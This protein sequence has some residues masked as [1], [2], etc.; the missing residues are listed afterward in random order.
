M[1]DF[2]NDLRDTSFSLPYLLNTSSIELFIKE[3]LTH[4]FGG[5]IITDAGQTF[6]AALTAPTP[7]D[8]QMC[9]KA[10]LT[11]SGCLEIR[12]SGDKRPITFSF[13]Y[14]IEGVFVFRSNASSSGHAQTWNWHPRFVGK[15][16]FKII[17]KYSSQPDQIDFIYRYDFLDG[18]YVAC[19]PAPID[20][21]QKGRNMP[22]SLFIPS[23][24]YLLPHSVE[25]DGLYPRDE[26]A[27]ALFSV[28]PAGV[29]TV[30]NT[31]KK[32]IQQII[33]DAFS[34]LTSEKLATV[35]EQDLQWQRLYTYSAYLTATITSALCNVLDQYLR[36]VKKQK[37]E[38]NSTD[39]WDLLLQLPRDIVPISNLI[40]KGQLHL[41]DPLNGIEALSKLSSFQRYPYS[42]AILD[43]LPPIFR[44]NHPS[45]QGVI[46]PV[47]SPE[48]LK[49]GIAL[50]LA[51][52]TQTD[53]IGHIRKADKTEIDEDL[54]RAA[55][56]VPFYQHNDGVRAMM[57]AKNLKQAAP[58]RARAKP[59]VTTG[60]ETAL[61]ETAQ[62]LAKAG[63]SE[64]N[65]AVDVGADLLVAYM[66]WYGWN[67]D[68]AIV[69]NERLVSDGSLDWVVENDY[70]EYLLPGFSLCA[71]V[72]ENTFEEAFKWLS[73]GKSGL[74]KLGPIRPEDPI[75]FFRNANGENRMPV[76]CRAEERGELVGLSYSPPPFDQCGGSLSWK[77][78]HHYPFRV[79]D[80]IMGRHGNKG[81]VAKILPPDE[82]PRLPD[83]GRLP[84]KLRGKPV[85]LILNPHGVISRMN[86]GQLLETSVG[87]LMQFKD[88]G[89]QFPQNVGQAF[90]KLDI[91]ALQ[92]YFVKINGNHHPPLFDPYGR[93]HMVMPSGP[94]TNAPVT[95][96]VQHILRLK[97][98]AERKAQVRAGAS[99]NNN[100][101]GYNLVSGQPVGGRR[102]KGGQRLGE[103]EMW[104]LAAHGAAKSIES[105]LTIK[106]DPAAMGEKLPFGQTFQAIKDHL[107]AM[108]IVCD[109]TAS[110]GLQLRWADEADIQNVC[111][112]VTSPGTWN[113]GV[114]GHFIC[115]ANRCSYQ[116]PFPSIATGSAQR[117]KQIRLTMND[118]L[119]AKGLRLPEDEAAQIPP[120]SGR[121]KEGD[122]QF[123]FL[124]ADG[125]RKK[126]KCTFHYKRGKRSVSLDFTI[127]RDLF[128]AYKQNDS[129][130]QAISLQQLGLFWLTCPFHKSKKLVEKRQ[131]IIPV[132]EDGG[133]CDQSIFGGTDLSIWTPDAFGAIRLDEAILYPGLRPGDKAKLKLKSG[134]F[135]LDEK[136]PPPDL[137]IFPVLPM[138]YRYR[139]P[140]HLGAGNL[141]Q[142]DLLT[143]RYSKLA[144]LVDQKADGQQIRD[145]ILG[146]IGIIHNRLFGK[147]GLLRRAGLGRRVDMSARLVIVPDP[148]LGWDTCAVPIEI[149]M[150]LLG[151]EISKHPEL[152]SEFAQVDGV[153][154]LIKAIFGIDLAEPQVPQAVEQMVLNQ[155]FWSNP[156]WPNKALAKDHLSLAGRV[157]ERYIELHPQTTVLLNRQ[158][159]LHR[160]SIMGFK[161]KVLPPDDG[162]VLKINPLVCNGFGADFD[163]DE[164]ALHMPITN[165][166]ML[167]AETMLPTAVANLFSNANG[168]PMAH[169][170]QDFVAG[171]FYLSLSGEGRH[172]LA[173]LF[174][175]LNCPD[176]DAILT[177][178]AP[179][180]KKHGQKMIDHLCHHHP[181]HAPSI[182]QEW[183]NLAYQFVTEQGMSFGFLELWHLRQQVT[184]QTRKFLADAEKITDPK[185]L[186][187]STGTFGNRLLEALEIDLPHSVQSP[188][189]GLAA[190]ALS[191]ARGTKQVRQLIGARGWLDPG[192]VG[193][194][195]Q[196]E[197]FFCKKS[198]V[199]GVNQD[200]SYFATMN[201]RSSM[202]DKKLGTGQAGYLTRRLVLAAWPW[203]VKTG[204]CGADRSSAAG[205][206]D[207]KWQEHCT[208]CSACYGQ[209]P[210][211]LPVP[212][213]YP[214]G[215]IAAQSFG[216]RGT[217]LSMQS[218]HTAERQLSIHEVV[219]LLGGRDP[220]PGFSNKNTQDADCKVKTYN[221]FVDKAD[222]PKYLERIR[223]ENGY[224]QIDER[225]LLLIW[226]VIH[227]SPEK[228]ISNAWRYSHS[229]LAGLIG[230]R[231]WQGLLQAICTGAYDDL[232]SP[233]TRILTSQ[234][235]V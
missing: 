1:P 92:E 203:R 234:S 233:L 49:V 132:H 226:L 77:I 106:S 91:D 60:H 219:A 138:K 11:L 68:D 88:K 97:H 192:A 199:E 116:L 19:P 100:R 26:V 15:P 74:R 72:F 40:T 65:L 34:T 195:P 86:L 168:Q 224:K 54:G 155:A 123:Q 147:M 25:D 13:P 124:A 63:I 171:H 202:L 231:Q 30:N 160:F 39:L 163:G 164:M 5:H 134:S 80:K 133:L 166:E 209:L 111:K 62:R 50:H 131:R 76:S 32:R 105:A 58:V 84:E 145:E 170:D 78:R 183:M 117:D 109:E 223:R 12:W 81:I 8:V 79:G 35:D 146:I 218:F 98:V 194:Q 89:F 220:E 16:G 83:D 154:D 129:P 43:R 198:L 33:S 210:P 137:T 216:E 3:R 46:C 143:S 47:E 69:A 29:V 227:R 37:T 14:P 125:K 59:V 215:L 156:I 169:F 141:P 139:A 230:P 52:N 142:N 149:L 6:S 177:E 66:P 207:C 232:N 4:L 118:L 174:G 151:P 107:F 113:V 184:E 119:A 188:G 196:S 103:M 189:F 186:S 172:K 217:Q 222:V 55:S 187:A 221:W 179:W 23:G 152:L 96:G 190:M 67:V 128:A 20:C 115:E 176:C 41:F 36:R 10:N 94:K 130:R 18:R 9:Q 24:T 7:D 87:M 61:D 161:I 85:D 22:F 27:D 140:K 101:Y 75:A 201:G 165:E 225:H 173:S 214:A 205:L 180:K 51:R 213:G 159:S 2:K 181:T 182:I 121:S 200:E 136:C 82:L 178:P 208:I 71:P 93:I 229:P 228:T 212:D 185:I 127:G 235:P 70:F 148:D 45:Y 21:T 31:N 95:V 175:S 204:D 114:E 191:G 150:A 44:Q 104:A 112:P 144:Q 135:K 153:D 73:Y 56:L 193:F 53:A 120:L 64:S 206:V 197:Q 57:G 126:L 108:G 162:M 110:E 157:I 158:P 38:P 28:F 102:R 48:S 167:E 17:K 211:D 99:R 90:S 122:I 42:K